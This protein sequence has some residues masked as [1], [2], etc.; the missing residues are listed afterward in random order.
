MKFRGLRKTEPETRGRLISPPILRV[1]VR[2][3]LTE[4]KDRA[5]S[6]L[7]FF[8][9]SAADLVSK[10]FSA[11]VI[12]VLATLFFSFWSPI[13]LGL[14]DS[15]A[16]TL[17]GFVFFAVLPVTPVAYFAR[18]GTTDIYVSKR[19]M[20]TPFFLV[21]LASYVFASAIFWVEQVKILFLL[22]IIYVCVTLAVMVTN[23]F[24]KISIHSAAIGGPATAIV[25]VFGAIAT[26]LYALLIPVIW[27]RVKLGAHT[28]SQTIIG[29][30]LSIAIT[31]TVCF[32]IFNTLLSA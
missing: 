31:L 25:Y 15:L 13:G 28:I 3:T 4:K 21:A 24:W 32:I 6:Y 8:K 29:M 1:N 26:P 5:E 22:S 27:A 30:V 2:Q 9:C 12:A 18:K 10:V 7:P 14:L 16:C 20:R 11:P 23:L 17:I 19:E